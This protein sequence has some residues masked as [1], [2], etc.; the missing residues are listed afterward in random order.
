VNSFDEARSAGDWMLTR[1][2]AL[3]QAVTDHPVELVV[4]G[5]DANALLD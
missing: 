5:L 4:S 2:E 3:D 1:T